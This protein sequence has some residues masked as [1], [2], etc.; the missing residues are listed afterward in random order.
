MQSMINNQRDRGQISDSMA[1][2]MALTQ[3]YREATSAVLRALGVTDG[4]FWFANEE[5]ASLAR[6]AGEA[7]CAKLQ[8]KF[9]AEDAPK[10]AEMVAA[11][12]K[13]AQEKRNSLLREE[14]STIINLKAGWYMLEGF[15]ARNNVNKDEFTEAEKKA[16]LQTGEN[17]IFEFFGESRAV[18]TETND[19]VFVEAE[20]V[21]AEELK[22]A[23]KTAKQAAKAAKI[24]AKKGRI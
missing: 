5:Q 12:A 21:N 7:A 1:R 11:E 6:N 22:A 2:G 18:V 3:C 10:I 23:R 19:F 4:D 14:I 24:A 16:L 20:S 17:A 9:D 13:A 8:E 15:I